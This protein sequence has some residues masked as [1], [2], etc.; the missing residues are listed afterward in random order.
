MTANIMRGLGYE[1]NNGVGKHRQ[2]IPNLV[3]VVVRP[4]NLNLSSIKKPKHVVSAK[5]F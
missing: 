3:E 5:A 1:P 2:G 4:K